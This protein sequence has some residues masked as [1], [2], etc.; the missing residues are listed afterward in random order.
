MKK[1]L[2]FSF[3][4]VACM[5]SQLVFSQTK[6]LKRTFYIVR[7][8]EKDTGSNPAIS[9]L[10]QKR[11]GDLYRQLKGKHID[12]IFVSQF[13]RTAMTGDSLRLYN[14]IDTMH[15]LADATGAS[16]LKK[17][18]QLPANVKTILIIGHSN[19][20]PAIVRLAGATDFTM[21]ELPDNEYDNLFIVKQGKKGAK[22]QQKKFGA[23][24][25]VPSAAT[26]MK[27][28]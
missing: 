23:A 15:Y 1:I 19:T 10:G 6:S 8:A 9:L 4:I 16:L 3:F 7:H 12:M 20:V 24:S 21:K 5:F 17:I 27:L 18:E 13:R 26:Q 28:K 11:A 25:P 14:K 22:L 2:Y